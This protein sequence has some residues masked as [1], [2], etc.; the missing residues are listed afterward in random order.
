MAKSTRPPANGFVRVMRTAYNPIGFSKGYNAILWFLTVGYIF[1]FTLSRLGYLSFG[2][3]FCGVNRTPGASQTLTMGVGLHLTCSQGPEQRLGSAIIG[4]KILLRLVCI[5]RDFEKSGC[6]EIEY[7]GMKIHL[8][9]ILPASYWYA[10]KS[11]LRFD[12]PSRS[13]TVSMGI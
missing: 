10:S 12:T 6:T 9:T 13:S 8:F 11:Y 2:T 7:V 5:V 3:V 1:G 4:Y